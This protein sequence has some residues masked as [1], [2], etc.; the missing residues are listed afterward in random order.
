[1]WKANV[2]TR[3]QYAPEAGVQGSYAMGF[4]IQC[5]FSLST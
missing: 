1:M 5:L 4:K 3:G 2:S